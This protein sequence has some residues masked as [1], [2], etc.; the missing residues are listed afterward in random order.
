MDMLLELLAASFL[1]LFVG[2]ALVQCI[3]IMTDGGKK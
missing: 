3:I 2:A 1:V